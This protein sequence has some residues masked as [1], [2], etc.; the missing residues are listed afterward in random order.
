M[1]SPSLF[2]NIKTDAF[3]CDTCGAKMMMLFGDHYCGLCNN[4]RKILDA[5]IHE[6]ATKEGAIIHEKWNRARD[7]RRGIKWNRKKYYKEIIQDIDK[8]NKNK[9]DYREY[10]Q[11][12]LEE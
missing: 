5:H 9:F 3:T 4:C 8:K 10:C 2:G 6:E 12:K 7:E 1:D 11:N